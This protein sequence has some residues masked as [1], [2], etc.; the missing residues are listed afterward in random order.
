MSDKQTIN[1]RR[2]LDLL[3][4]FQAAMEHPQPIPH[5]DHTVNHLA[6]NEQRPLRKASVLIP[7]TRAAPGSSSQVILTVRSENLSSHAGQIS[8]PGGTKEDHDIDVFA[9]ALRE[10]EEEIGLLPEHVE[11]IGKLG[12]MALPSGYEVTPV[13]GIITAGLEL[14]PCPIEVAD[15]FHAPLDL[16]LDPDAYIHSSMMFNNKPRKIMELHF[17]D[18]RIW[19]ATAAIL[20]HLAKE[21]SGG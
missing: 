3:N 11:I 8:L 10:S 7:I 12:D 9:T 19:G 15:I 18:Y 2:Y 1:S 16:V 13:V 21:T 6:A 5:P 20:Y 14:T 17:E 4:Y